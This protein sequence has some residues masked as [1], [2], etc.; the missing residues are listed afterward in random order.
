[1]TGPKNDGR[2]TTVIALTE[3]QIIDQLTQ[4]LADAHSDIEAAQVAKVV[5]EQYAR[6]EGL[7]FRDYVPLFVERNAA[8][9]LT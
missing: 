9:E 2:L 6:F 3:Q 8:A 4:R 1:M 5:Y 7:P